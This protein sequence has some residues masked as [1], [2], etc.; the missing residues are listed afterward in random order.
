MLEILIRG[1]FQEQIIQMLDEASKDPNSMCKV[2]KEV[3]DF[4]KAPRQPL[5][6]AAQSASAAS[7]KPT[8]K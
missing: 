3:I 2:P 6:N 7:S 5:A 1:G 4:I 8:Q